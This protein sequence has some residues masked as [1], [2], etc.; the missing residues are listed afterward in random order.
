M[1]IKLLPLWGGLLVGLVLLLA[2]SARAEGVWTK[3][4]PIAAV[5][6]K[7]AVSVSTSA[8]TKIPASSSLGQRSLLKVMNPSSNNASMW[9]TIDS[10]TPTGITV[11]EIEIQK[12]QNPT[13]PIGRG[14]DL[15]CVSKHTSA[16]SVG[17]RE[18]RQ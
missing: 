4:L 12:G 11:A 8:F 16:E 9:C 6:A 5:G 7:T 17:V 14:L 1:K 10:S 13:I 3:D 18:M 2:P 15:Y